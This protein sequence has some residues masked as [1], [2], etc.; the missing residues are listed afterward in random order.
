MHLCLEN[1]SKNLV[2]L[3][4]GKYKGLDEG[5]ESYCIPDN[6]WEIIG[7]ETALAGNTIPSSF[8]CHTPNIWSEKH[9][10]TAEDWAFW[11]VHIAPYVLR[12][13]FNCPKYY[14]HFM[15]FNSI[16]KRALTKH[17]IQYSF[18]EQDLDELEQDIVEYVKEYEIIYYQFSAQRLSTCPLMLHV[19]LHIPYDIRNNGPPCNNWTFIMERWCGSLLPAI[20]SRKEP[21]TCL[22]LRQYQK[23]Q[24]F[25][26][27]NR[28]NLVEL[29]P[30][31]R[32]MD[33]PSRYE[34]LFKKSAFISANSI[35]ADLI[36]FLRKP[37]VQQY[38]PDLSIRKKIAKHLTTSFGGSIGSWLDILLPTMPCWAKVHIGNGGDLI[39]GAVGQMTG[40][41]A[42]CDASFVRYELHAD[43]NAH[44]PRAKEKFVR[45]VYYGCLKYIL[46]CTIPPNPI[47][48]NTEPEIVLL[49]VV[50]T[51]GTQGRDA[52]L[53]LTYFKAVT[54]YIEIVDLASI[55][56]VVGRIRISVVDPQWAIVD[57]SGSWART[58]FT[59]DSLAAGVDVSQRSEL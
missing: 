18:T 29:M 6:V 3:W 4:Q 12:N 33:V 32:D 16:L 52:T 47:S 39:R 42:F 9:L 36:S 11:M 23:V 45:T 54:S 21:F 50:T 38:I 30:Q 20:K 22:A 43:A 1:H 57:C 34:Q 13:H 27:V 24:L 58:V 15:K 5:S 49:A 44:R 41:R 35:Y 14:K 56:A 28:Y 19:L 40:Q 37:V 2:T 25:E 53:E 26:V 51:C 46:Q 7:K 48:K 17:T 10:F 31:R 59:D 8:G 55:C